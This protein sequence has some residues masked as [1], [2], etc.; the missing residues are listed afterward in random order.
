MILVTFSVQLMMLL[1]YNVS[2]YDKQWETSH[3]TLLSSTL[4]MY[5]KL[6]M[7]MARK[8]DSNT[9]GDNSSSDRTKTLLSFYAMLFIKE[10]S[11]NQETNLKS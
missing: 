7:I 4:K 3:S 9:S 5:N 8:L 11:E 1:S 2:Q 6:D 10:E